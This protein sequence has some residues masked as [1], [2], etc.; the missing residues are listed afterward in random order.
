MTHLEMNTWKQ[1]I[2]ALLHP[3][4][5]QVGWLVFRKDQFENSP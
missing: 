5:R 3:V 1:G 4:K 2:N